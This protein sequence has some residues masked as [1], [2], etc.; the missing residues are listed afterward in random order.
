MAER[1]TILRAVV[2]STAHGLN[3]PSSDDRDE[4]GICVE[5]LENVI[6]FSPFEQHIYR[7]AAEREGKQDAPSKPGDL[8]LTIYSLRKYLN[9]ALQ[10]N[11]SV[12]LLLFVKPNN[13]VVC[14]S[15]G[16]QLQELA[17]HIISKH[18]GK[19]F[20]GYMTAQRMRLLST[21]L[22]ESGKPKD[23]YEWIKDLAG[24]FNWPL[25]KRGQKDVHRPEL[26]EKYGYDT[27]YAMHILRL[28][29]QGIE[30]M[31]TGKLTLPME[32]DIREHLMNV[33]Q[34]K[35][36]LR[37]VLI[38]AGKIEQELEKL[39]RTSSLPDTPSYDVVERWMVDTYWQYWRSQRYFM[40]VA[41]LLTKEIN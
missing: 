36:A 35:V 25:E 20:A 30:L 29:Y 19:R 5:S 18:C 24:D 3:L 6:G 2:G 8:D 23:G 12:L 14:T 1:Q 7:T 39:I 28:G 22:V 33:R 38:E 17:P 40:D 16:S 34:G 21:A 15:L 10:G 4:M 37:E 11:P 31:T 26:E 13:C 32:G 41:N 27:K 9:L